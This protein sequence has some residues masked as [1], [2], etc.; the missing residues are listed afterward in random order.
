MAALPAFPVNFSRNFFIR[1]HFPPSHRLRPAS[2]A[3]TI[4][5]IAPTMS[6]PTQTHGQMQPDAIQPGAADQ[7]VLALPFG[8]AAS[9]HAP[10]G[11]V[12][13]QQLRILLLSLASL[14][15]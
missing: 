5:P 15:T 2:F 14:M 3:P 7:N 10:V 13:Q 8:L 11:Q 6:H 4:A 9:M 1:S 12:P